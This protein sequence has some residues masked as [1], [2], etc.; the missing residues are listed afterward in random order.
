MKVE[1]HPLTAED[2]KEAVEFYNQRR[3]G[4]GDELRTEVYAAAFDEPRR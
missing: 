2:L 3:A 1:Y 4:L